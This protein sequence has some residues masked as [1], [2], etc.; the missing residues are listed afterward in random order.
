MMLLKRCRNAESGSERERIDGV[1]TIVLAGGSASSRRLLM[2]S[3]VA[4]VRALLRKQ[5]KRC[6]CQ[7]PQ[8]VLNACMSYAR[9]PG[10]SDRSDLNY[11]T[12][13]LLAGQSLS[14]I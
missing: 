13:A 1:Y 9:Q 2:R 6:S 11:C 14:P 4:F 5:G 8:R 10:W 7:Q 12:P 3:G